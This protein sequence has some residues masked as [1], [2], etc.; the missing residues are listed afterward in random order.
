[1]LFRLDLKFTIMEKHI[2]ILP[3][4][5][6]AAQE[7]QPSRSP[8]FR[9]IQSKDIPEAPGTLYDLFTKSVARNP[10]NECAMIPRIH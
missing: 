4:T 9:H 6:R 2:Y 3:K 7:G 1:V 8:I 5:G 10:E